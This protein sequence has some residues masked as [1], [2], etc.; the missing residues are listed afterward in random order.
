MGLTVHSFA[1]FLVDAVIFRDE[2]V[3]L[4]V[5]A[6][7]GAY[8][9]FVVDVVTGAELVVVSWLAVTEEECLPQALEICW[10]LWIFRERMT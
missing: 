9:V 4:V 7:G 1:L 5:W 10:K 6:G 8:L 3:E 2:E